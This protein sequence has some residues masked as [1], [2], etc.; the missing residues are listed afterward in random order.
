MSGKSGRK[1]IKVIRETDY[2]G[3]TDPTSVS[4]TMKWEALA[5]FYSTLRLTGSLC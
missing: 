5:D 1:E 4:H 3:H 2:I